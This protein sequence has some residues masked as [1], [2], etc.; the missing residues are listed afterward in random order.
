M[1]SQ[2]SNSKFSIKDDHSKGS[3]LHSHKNSIESP[4]ALI[5]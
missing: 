3:R 1:R 4:S 5:N 2:Q